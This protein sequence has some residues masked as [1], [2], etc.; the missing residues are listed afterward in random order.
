MIIL[1]PYIVEQELLS[2]IFQ[3]NHFRVKGENYIPRG[4]IIPCLKASKMISKGFLYHILRVKYLDSQN[5]PV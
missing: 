3:M 1:L 2:S 5:P 4:R